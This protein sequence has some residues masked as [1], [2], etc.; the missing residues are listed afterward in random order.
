[1][2]QLVSTV[3]SGH[4]LAMTHELEIYVETKNISCRSP[5]FT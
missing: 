1:M 4:P 2:W 5:P 3:K